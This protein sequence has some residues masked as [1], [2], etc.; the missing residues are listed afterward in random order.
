M[1]LISKISNPKPRLA[2]KESSPSTT[3]VRTISDIRLLRNV[4][5]TAASVVTTG[6]GPIQVVT[7]PQQALTLLAAAAAAPASASSTTSITNSNRNISNNN[8]SSNINSNSAAISSN[9]SPSTII[10]IKQESIPVDTLTGNYVDST[11]FLTGSP[12]SSQMVNPNLVQSSTNVASTAGATSAGDS[13]IHTFQ[14]SYRDQVFY[15]FIRLHCFLSSSSSINH[16]KRF[17]ST[18]FK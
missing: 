17:F 15:Y 2:E 5:A 7:T 11:T 8:S 14:S 10:T 16:S 9:N 3:T 18:F 13:L 1:I 4:V 6:S 12:V